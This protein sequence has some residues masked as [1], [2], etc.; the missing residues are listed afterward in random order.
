[1]F[2][3]TPY[4]GRLSFS[5]TIPELQLAWDST[6]V[7]S[8]KECP[9]KYYYN[10]VFGWVPREE[11]VHLTFGL[12]YHSS[13]EAY[14][15]AKAMGADHNQALRFA[16]RHALTVTWNKVLNRPW[17]SDH[18]YKNRFTLVRS[19]VWYLSKFKDDPL[20]TVILKNGKPAVELSWRM[21]LG[22]QTPTG[23]QLVLC[24]H[25]DRLAVFQGNTWIADRKTT[26]HALT[27]DFFDRYSPDNQFSTYSYAG[28]IIYA[29]PIKG[30]IAD[31]A[32]IL[33]EG[34][35]FHRGFIPR[36]IDQLE[37]W[38]HDL[39]W[40]LAQAFHAAKEGYWPQNDKSCGLYGGCPYRQICG[41][42]PKVRLD[43][44]K[45]GFTRRKWDP[46]V[47]RGDI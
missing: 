2:D 6:S 5:T 27:D 42:S 26:Y 46:L 45:A 39:D 9:R 44:L 29:L 31:V 23:E 30:I 4:T 8:F 40:W 28:Q 47:A 14:D 35:R 12:H 21:E 1:M 19:V 16:V 17:F 18:K 43:W 37:E 7:G 25:L 41:R 34:T 36:H 10:I 13:L 22:T 11:S 15:R 33:V 38:R 3:V 20:E 24:G 32:Q